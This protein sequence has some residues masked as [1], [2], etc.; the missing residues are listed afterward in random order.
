[1]SGKRTIDDI[2]RLAGVSKAT[3]SR[4]LNHK[5]DVDPT[6]R[7]RILR[8]VEEQ[9]F[10]PSIT[11]SGLAGGQSRLIGVLVPSFTW[12]FI[13]D[14]MRGISEVIGFTQ[15][16]IILYSINDRIRGHDYEHEHRQVIDRILSTKLTSGL[17]AVY[18]GPPTSHLSRL[19]HQNFP[20]VVIDDQVRPSNMPWIGIDNMTAAYTAVRHLVELGH[21][22]IA[23]IQG[24]M[25]FLC[26]QERYQGY[27][28]ALEEAGL[29]P[30]PALAL[31]GDF[32]PPGGR[33]CANTFFALPPEQRP[34]AIFA[35]NDQMA[36]GV[37]ASAE[38]HGIS[39]PQDVALVGFDD[40]SSFAS[41]ARLRP[42]LTT[43][44]QP[45]YEMGQR[46]AELLLT[47]LERRR[48]SGA[49]DYPLPLLRDEAGGH[50]NTDGS[51]PIRIYLPSS[52]IVRAS[53]GAPHPSIIPIPPPSP[54]HA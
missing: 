8:I 6:T 36:Y 15:Y 18:P 47:M 5:P 24:P 34:T 23:H 38:E 29:T 19:H 46:A 3:V 9:G 33:F 21:K 30:D 20:V 16:E 13:P 41:S 27:R 2:A 25:K 42:A 12:P 31:E 37:L 11:A 39:I 54:D 51:D 32:A 7:E 40:I 50:D 52:L 45:F 53:C 28:Q 26:S 22:R 4:V 1:M 49:R 35:A 44:R 43:I 17:L 10:V 14:V 48:F